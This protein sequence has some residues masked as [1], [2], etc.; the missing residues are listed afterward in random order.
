MRN[1]FENLGTVVDG[2][3]ELTNATKLTNSSLAV[4]VPRSKG[5]IKFDHVNF[6]YLGKTR[7][8]D[9]QVFSDSIIH[10][11]PG[12]I[13]G[14]VGR[15]GAGKSTLVNLLLRFYEVHSGRILIDGQDINDLTQ[16]SLRHQI[17]MV[18]Q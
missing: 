4:V 5:E 15:S 10:I 2:I 1:L 14:L 17:G 8:K 13:I 9:H 7:D 11:K 12:E 3:D 6:I 16:D 18:T